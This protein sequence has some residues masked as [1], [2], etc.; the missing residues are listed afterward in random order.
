MLKIGS[1]ISSLYGFHSDPIGFA[2]VE[3]LPLPSTKGSD[4]SFFAHLDGYS[5]VPSQILH[6]NK[7]SY[8]N[9]GDS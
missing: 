6:R 5:T 7:V 9:S 2:D 3:Y 8:Q 1:F 4:F